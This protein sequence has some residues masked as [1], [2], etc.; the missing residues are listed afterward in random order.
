MW[1]NRAG[2]LFN[3][4][5]VSETVSQYSLLTRLPLKLYRM[6]TLWAVG[7]DLLPSANT[8]PGTTEAAT[9]PWSIMFPN[10]AQ[11]PWW[12]QGVMHGGNL[13][14]FLNVR[15]L[16][17]HTEILVYRA[18]GTCISSKPPGE[19]PTAA[20]S[21]HS[22]SKVIESWCEPASRH[23]DGLDVLLQENILAL[24]NHWTAS[25]FWLLSFFTV[26]KSKA[27]VIQIVLLQT[28][29]PSNSFIVQFL[30]L[31]LPIKRNENPVSEY[32]DMWWGTKQILRLDAGEIVSE[33]DPLYELTY[34]IFAKL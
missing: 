29:I 2:I 21:P 27:L 24:S 20:F 7:R 14:A 23:R 4:P 30:E 16:N 32:R 1:L 8:N 17:G 25:W 33:H 12:G 26:F 31:F 11:G 9:P 22:S 19:A 28:L 3:I 13:L 6:E 18:W 10:G 5:S 34:L 15:E